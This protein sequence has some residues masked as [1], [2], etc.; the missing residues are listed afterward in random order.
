M[1]RLVSSIFL[2]ILSFYAV[3]QYGNEWIRFDQPYLKIQVAAEGLCSVSYSDLSQAGLPLSADPATFQLFHRGK[4]QAI[5]V[6]GEADGMFNSGD[7]LEFYGTANDGV[8]DAALYSDPG[9]Q[10]HQLYNLFSDTTSYFLTWGVQTG[11]RIPLAAVSPAGLIPQSWHTAEQLVVLTQSYS[12]GAD[13]GDVHKSVFDTGEGWMGPQILQNQ[14]QTYTVEGITETIPGAGKPRLEVLLTGRGPM[15]HDVALSS[16]N[17]LLGTVNFSAFDSYQYE[18]DLEWSDIGSD[19][20][21]FLKVRVTGAGGADRVSVGYI[22]VTFPQALTM[23]GLSQKIFYPPPADGKPALLSIENAP[24][25]TRLFDVTDPSRV[26]RIATQLTSSGLAGVIPAAATPRKV[27]ASAAVLSPGPVK[28]V[29]FRKIIPGS[30]DYVIIT[31]PSLRRPAGGLTDPV[32]AYAEYRSLPE[33]GGFDTLVVNIGQLYDQF[34]YG[35]TS[36]RAIFQFMKFLSGAQ[37]PDYLFL[38]GKGLDVNYGFHRNPA[39]FTRYRDL[40]PTGGY[41]ASD[42]VFTAGLSGTPD[43]AGVA[44]GRLTANDPSDVVAYLNKVRERDALPFDDLW[45]KKILHLSGGIET[46]EP[47]LF[48]NIMKG[49]EPAAEGVWLGGSVEAIAKK[50]TGIKV[51]NIAEKVNAGLGL[52]T[53][54]GHS[55]PNTLDFDIGLVTD[56]VMGYDNSAK[57]PFLLMNGCNVGSFFLN[58]NIFGENWIKTPGKG[59]IGFIAHSAYGRIGGLQRY[60]DTFYQVAFADSTFIHRGVGKVQQEVAKRYIA[61][62]EASPLSVSQTQQMVLL[63]DPAVKLFGAE[64]PDYAIDAEAIFASAFDDQPLTALSD[65]FSLHIP[66]RNFG[67]A[68]DE[69]LHV[70]VTRQYANGVVLEYD[71][72]YAPVLFQDTLTLIIR[73]ADNRGFGVNSFSIRVDA[74]DQIDELSESN[75]TAEYTYFI[76]LGSTRNLYPYNFGIVQNT[77]VDLSFQHTDLRSGARAFAVEID[78]VHTFDSDFKQHFIVEAE[79]LGRQRVALLQ[80]DSVV[81]YWRTR[82][83]DPLESESKDWTVSSFSYLSAGPEGWAQLRFPQYES[84]TMVGLTQDPELKRIEFPETRSDIAIK[85]FSALAGKPADSV[86]LK[87][88]HVEFNLSHEGDGC[89]NNTLNLVAF[90]KRSTQPYAGIYFKWYDLLAK[91]GGRRLICGREPYVIN[92]FTPQELAT[93][94]HDDLIQYIDNVKTGD[95]VVL[96]NIG[97]AGYSSWPGAAVAKLGMLGVSASQL[98]DLADGDAVVIFGMK[99]APPGSATIFR[100]SASAPRLTVHKTIAGRFTSGSMASGLIGPASAWGGLSAR[101]A[102]VEASD[103]YRISIVG[104]TSDHAVDT[105]KTNASLQEDLSFIDAGQYPWLKIILHVEDD[106]NLTAAQLMHWLVRYEPVPEGLVYYRGDGDQWDVLEGEAVSADFGFINVSNKSF[107]DSLVVHYDLLNSRRGDDA[108]QVSKIAAPLPGDTTLFSLAFNTVS[109][110]GIND[111][112]VFVNPRLQQEMHYENNRI[113]LPEH[114]LV[115][116]DVLHPVLDVTFDGRHLENNDFVATDPRIA[117][118]LWDE[119]PLIRK[120]DTLNVRIFLARPCG[121]KV[122]DFERIYFLRDDVAWEPASATSDYVVYFSPRQLADG[123]YVLRVE[124]SDARANAA[125]ETPYEIAFRVKAG[126]SLTALQPYPNP[127]VYEASFEIVITGSKDALYAYDL[128]VSD[129]NGVVVRTLS[130]RSGELHPGKNLIVWNGSGNDGKRLPDGLYF[131]KLTIRGAGHLHACSGKLLLQ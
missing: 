64:K 123:A 95:S 90:D 53:F 87:I 47:V 131:Y 110:D 65:S 73:N 127:F 40:V 31:H 101:I 72:L 32:K 13:Y 111:V 89:R 75:N 105:L 11:R 6:H 80:V 52:I 10:P 57:Y 124:A 119:N 100:G 94:N 103:R 108:H 125:G 93:G 51:V 112:D 36:P 78:T 62:F 42:M 7:Y 98:A 23:S 68:R 58:A 26:V 20:K 106:V 19:G 67:I 8:P 9:S 15:N 22:R 85:T 55:A 45:R 69:D 130:D 50:S 41:P 96:F 37:L 27:Y 115:A 66:V 35:E 48:A 61:N 28:N 25:D 3:G 16:A 39:A 12:T 86:S 46:F 44:T 43:V 70:A 121:E 83:A 122:C 60:S 17:R 104:V 107:A 77:T 63:G 38:V 54:F 118:R 71:S 84:N 109:R 56:P 2:S 92:S 129:V 117:I 76:P 14:E 97:D 21:F 5:V 4:E 88:N 120:T 126:Q 79:I 81:Y 18:A 82:I 114:V 49:F 116:K 91:Y 34:N 30:A 74:G 102:A 59:A 24:A 29:R 1:K 128:Q 99:G 113:V 33:G